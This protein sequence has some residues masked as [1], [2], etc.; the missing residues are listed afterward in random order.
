[1]ENS[2]NTSAVDFIVEGMK[3]IRWVSYSANC[4]VERDK[5]IQTINDAKKIEETQK[6]ESINKAIKLFEEAKSKAQ[7]L[8]DIVYLDGVLSILDSCKIK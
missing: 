4:V 2:E 6:N 1:M 8:R 3:H 5:M 7:S